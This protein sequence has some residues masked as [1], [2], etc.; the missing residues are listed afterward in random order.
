MS[1]PRP[2]TA[3]E[4]PGR[5]QEIAR[6]LRGTHHL[7]PEAQQALAE[8]ADELG[9]LLDPS[10]PPE[11]AGRL[12]ESTGHVVEALREKKSAGMVGAARQRLQK[13]VAEV[14]SHVPGSADF[15]RRLLDVLANLGI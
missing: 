13:T 12:L 10:T 3:D 8:L 14:E 5:L 7:G 15:V 4:L 1:T 6:L 9:K 11:A 2:L